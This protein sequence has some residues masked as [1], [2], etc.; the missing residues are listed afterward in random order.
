MKNR[1]LCRL[2]KC[3]AAMGSACSI[4][5]YGHDPVEMEAAIYA[6]FD[7]LRRIEALLSVFLPASEWSEINRSAAVKEVTVSAEVHT[8]LSSCMRYSKESE[9]A[10]DITVGPL[11]KAWGVCAGMGRV[12]TRSELEA[13]MLNVGYRH[14]RLDAAALSV[15]LERPGME[16]N[17]GGI[18]KG[19]AVDRMAEVLRH[20][21]FRTALV[22]ASASSIY[23]MGIP[24]TESE[25]W[26]ITVPSLKNP[27]MSSTEMFLR[28]RSISTS[29]T[30]EKTF[31]AD[32]RLFSH[33]I[34][35]RS[36]Y[37]VQGRRMV[38]VVAPRTIDSEAWTKAFLLNGREWAVRNKPG[39]FS[40]LLSEEGNET[41]CTWL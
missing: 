18:G 33:I 17:P 30:Y 40:V 41:E 22:T 10:F 38:S 25:G 16:I 1:E 8:L 26:R 2:E 29:A 31:W 15:R 27:R 7:E 14:I 13:A 39:D 20:Y 24:P 6:A 36:G 21:G 12:P 11:M 34:D 9:G 32:G 37:P 28:D 4:V 5:L 35:P 3:T 19:F 23:G